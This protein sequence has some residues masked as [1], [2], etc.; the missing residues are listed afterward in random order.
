MNIKI[1]FIQIIKKLYYLIKKKKKK[2][3]KSTDICKR[4]QH[5]PHVKRHRVKA[6]AQKK[7]K[8]KKFS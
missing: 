2:N 7:K 4:Y 6:T 3:V 1:Q 5:E 8:V